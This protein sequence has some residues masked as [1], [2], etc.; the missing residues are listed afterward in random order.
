VGEGERGF[1]C[2]GFA[3]AMSDGSKLL[4]YVLL[5]GLRCA[6]V[7]SAGVIGALNSG[8]ISSDFGW[9]RTTWPVPSAQ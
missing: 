5:H 4:A 3:T 9:D 2:R 8:D 7:A 1:R 6:Y